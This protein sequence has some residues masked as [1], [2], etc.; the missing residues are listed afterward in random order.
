MTGDVEDFVD[1]PLSSWIEST[2]GLT[3][4]DERLVRAIPRTI[5]GTG[6]GAEDL[7]SVTGEE[8]RLEQVLPLVAKH[9]G[10]TL[11]EVNP[12]DTPLSQAYDI[13]MRMPA[14]EAMARLCEG[15]PAPS[16]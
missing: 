9:A 11:V 13:H 14:T 12:E 10:A 16:A 3:T 1:D 2:F 7:A 8:E 6:G 5:T 15:L 4:E